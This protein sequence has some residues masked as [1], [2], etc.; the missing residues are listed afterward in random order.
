MKIT[1][2]WYR[3]TIHENVL[4]ALSLREMTKA[5]IPLHTH[6]PVML[7]HIGEHEANIIETVMLTVVEARWDS[8]WNE[9]Y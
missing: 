5:K 9:R 8:Y 6:I 4:G 2:P 7:D 3:L 1:S